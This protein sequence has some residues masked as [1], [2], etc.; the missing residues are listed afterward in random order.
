MAEVRFNGFLQGR[1]PLRPGETR[2]EAVKRAERTLGGL[3]T[4]G[5][6]RLRVVLWLEDADQVLSDTQEAA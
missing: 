2:A 5:A 1:V 6:R 4:R 3:A